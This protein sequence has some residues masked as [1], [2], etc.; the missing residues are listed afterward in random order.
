MSE[1]SPATMNDPIARPGPMG[2][3]EL[4]DLDCQAMVGDPDGENEFQFVETT[5]LHSGVGCGP[6]RPDPDFG[7]GPVESPGAG[8]PSPHQSIDDEFGDVSTGFRLP[9]RVLVDDDFG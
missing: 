7:V 4:P 6:D 2:A 9:R 8:H 5:I 3:F 1:P